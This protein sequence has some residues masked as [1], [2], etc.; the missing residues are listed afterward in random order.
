ML[1]LYISYVDFQPTQSGSATRPQ[2]MYRAFLE[3]GHEVKLLAVSQNRDHL[4]RRKQAV[5]ELYA[6]LED[7]TPDLCYIESPVY[8]ILWEFD[9]KLIRD[10]HKKGIPTAYFTRDCYDRFPE[11]FP[12]RRDLPGKVKDA[13]LRRQRVLTEKTL[14]CVDVNYFPVMEMAQFYPYPDKRALPPGA[15]DRLADSH[16]QP[17]RLVYVGGIVNQ[18]G[19][20]ALLRAFR[21][22]NEGEETYT[23]TLVCRESE[24]AQIPDELKGAPWLDLHH[25]SGDALIPLLGAASAGLII[26][27]N[28]YWDYTVPIKLYEYMGYGLP[29]VYFHNR[30]TDRFM[31]NCPMG[32]GA[33]K[34]PEAFAEAIRS[35]LADPER[36]ESCRRNAVSA[37]KDGNLWIHRVRQIVRDLSEK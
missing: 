15:E 9:R 18:Y 6:W 3:E 24:W 35:L 26:G 16:P 33:D 37:L 17:N 36:W 8:P 12:G 29:V 2:K 10:I 25:T 32:V 30:P 19:G 4:K 34:T 22:L 21:I 27:I 13:W 5:K 31:E 11:M 1:V 20:E 7:H 23:L 14:M 28:D